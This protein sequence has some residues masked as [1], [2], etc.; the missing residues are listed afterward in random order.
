MK[1]KQ[2]LSSLVIPFSVVCFMLSGCF[3]S[4]K[5]DVGLEGADVLKNGPVDALIYM[6]KA[7]QGDAPSQYKVANYYYDKTHSYKE[8]LKWYFQAAKQGFAPA[9]AALGQMYDQGVGIKADPSKALFWY[10]QAADRND[11]E[12]Q[13]LLANIYEHGL[14]AEKQLADQLYIKA[15]QTFQDQAKLGDVT[16]QRALGMIYFEGLNNV[17]S[18]FFKQDIPKARLWLSRA[19]N[20]NDPKAQF[21]LGQ[22]Y[23][24]YGIED[25][26]PDVKEAIKWY[27]KAAK[28]NYINALLMLGDIYWQAIPAKADNFQQSIDYYTK[29]SELGSATADIVLAEHFLGYDSN[30]AGTLSFVVDEKNAIK[31]LKVAAI[32]KNNA[33]AQYMLGMI[34]ENPLSSMPQDRVEAEKWYKLAIGNRHEMAKQALQQMYVVMKQE[35]SQNDGAIPM[36]IGVPTFTQESPLFP[37]IEEH[38]IDVPPIPVIGNAISPHKAVDSMS[39]NHNRLS[40]SVVEQKKEN[41]ATQAQNIKT[42]NQPQVRRIEETKVQNNRQAQNEDDHDEIREI[43]LAVKENQ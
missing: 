18:S 2:Y 15:L 9:Q 17:R 8:A 1:L 29:A 36:S 22:L 30:E 20:Q 25:G 12:G 32:Q 6:T 26:L 3:D 40:G 14:D 39:G 13:Y 7:Q 38:N 10:Q 42:Q 43:P 41:P 35:G 4:N 16:A 27:K 24:Q 34:Y 33:E 23:A 31:W 21:L 11:P 37:V 19:A 5:A 28:Q